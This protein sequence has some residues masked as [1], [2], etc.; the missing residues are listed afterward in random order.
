VRALEV[1]PEDPNQVFPVMDLRWWEVLEPGSG[2]VRQKEEEV[3]NDEVITVCSSELAGQ[4]VV[5][6]PELR[7]RFP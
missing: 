2:V 7:L 1:S 5:S 6:K 3:T 4:S